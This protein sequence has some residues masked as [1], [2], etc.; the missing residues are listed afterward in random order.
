M[1]AQVQC[2]CDGAVRRTTVKKRTLFPVWLEMLT[3]PMDELAGH[4]LALEVMDRDA[5]SAA[6]FMGRVTVELVWR[7]VT[8][9][10]RFVGRHGIVV[11]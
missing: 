9:L 1:S 5:V 8:P 2:E 10:P 3:F 6:D 4:E 11:R 7:T